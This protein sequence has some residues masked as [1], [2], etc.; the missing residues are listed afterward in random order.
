MVFGN[1]LMTSLVTKLNM[2]YRYI[3]LIQKVGLVTT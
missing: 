1:Y 3:I 2:D